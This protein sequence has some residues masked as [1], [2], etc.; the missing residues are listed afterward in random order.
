MRG[1]IEP[2]LAGHGLLELLHQLR[3]LGRGPGGAVREQHFLYGIGLE[4]DLVA[5]AQQAEHIAAGV[6]FPSDRIGAALHPEQRDLLGG[7]AWGD[8]DA[9]GLAEV[10]PI[11]DH[12]GAATGTQHIGV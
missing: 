10:R 8:D 6:E 9:V 1:A 7:K 5:G 3:E 11:E 12:V 4:S 2:P